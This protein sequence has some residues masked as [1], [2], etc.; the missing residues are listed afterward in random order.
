MTEEDKVMELHNSGMS[1]RKIATELEIPYK[2]VRNIITSVK[3]KQLDEDNEDE[4]SE[5]IIESESVNP[6]SLENEITP[7]SVFDK[8]KVGRYWMR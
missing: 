8:Y 6:V 5:P 4:S 7:M 2:T 3:S 1:I